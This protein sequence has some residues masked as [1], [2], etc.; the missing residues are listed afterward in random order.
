MQKKK[1]DCLVHEILFIR[2]LKPNLNF[3]SDSIRTFAPLLILGLKN[4]F[5]CCNLYYLMKIFLD[6]G[7]MTTTKRQILSAFFHFML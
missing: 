3:Q 1:K 6:N 2:A 5:K 4:R 7:V